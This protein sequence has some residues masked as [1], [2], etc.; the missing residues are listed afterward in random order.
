MAVHSKMMVAVLALVTTYGLSPYA[1]ATTPTSSLPPSPP[2]AALSPEGSKQPLSEP[3]PLFSQEMANA[4]INTALTFLGPRTLEPHT[5]QTF[6]QW[7][8]NGVMAIDPSLG[9]SKQG[10]MLIFKM[11]QKLLLSERLPL[12]TDHEG[13]ARLS[14]TIMYKAWSASP[15]MQKMGGSAIMQSFF[16]ELFN[17]L[18]PYSRYVPP[19]PAV[20]D[21]A[22][23]EGDKANIGI[24]VKRQSNDLVISAV[25]TNGPGWTAGLSVGQ[26]ILAIDGHSTRHITIEAAQTLLEGDENSLVAVTVSTPPSRRREVIHI[27]RALTPPETVF[28]YLSGQTIILRIAYFSVDTAQEISQYLDQ[29]TQ[30]INVKGVIFDLRGNRGGVLQQ[31]ITTAALIMNNGV[32]AVTKGRDPQANHIWAVQGG[33]LTQGAPLIILVD[34]RT[35]SAAEILAA[36]LADQHRGVVVGSTTL[37]KGLV[38]TIAQL[39]DGGELFVT[40]SRVLAP[41]GWPLQGLG[42][43]PQL[44]TSRGEN[45]MQQQLQILAAGKKANS[46]AILAS[47]SARYPIAAARILEIRK[48][49]PAAIGTDIDLEAARALLNNPTAYK[50]AISSIPEQDAN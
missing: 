3:V 36:A 41:L 26:K 13:W 29:V 46:E 14:S 10:N 30:D 8:L 39:P 15:V 49:C 40:W 43:M 16:D 6:S 27:H 33:D 24:T 31:A 47:R 50:M 2:V 42:V 19:A 48:A 28:A 45:V 1:L 12:A 32:A 35:A 21:R 38:Q 9:L 34:G 7:G 25:N 11:G 17:H 4:V 22:S 37:G 44:C 18:D 20:Q 23:R 5:S